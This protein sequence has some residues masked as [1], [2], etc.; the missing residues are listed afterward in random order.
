MEVTSASQEIISISWNQMFITAVT[1]ARHLYVFWTRLI[2]YLNLH[3]I[4]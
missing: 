4:S 2:Q 3:S 1:I